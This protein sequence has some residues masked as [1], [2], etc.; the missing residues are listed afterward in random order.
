MDWLPWI[1][2]AGIALA[3]VA[4][5]WKFFWSVTFRG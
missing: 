3:A 4:V 5:T 2:L 1:L